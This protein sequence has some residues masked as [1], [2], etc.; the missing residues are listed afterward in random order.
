MCSIRSCRTPRGKKAYYGFFGSGLFRMTSYVRSVAICTQSVAVAMLLAPGVPAY[1]QDIAVKA[2]QCDACHG[3]TGIPSDPAT[4]VIWG[5]H[6]AYLARQIGEFKLGSRVN[7]QMLLL[8]RDM[9]DA[10]IVALAAHYAQK[11]PPK[12]NQPHASDAEEKRAQAAIV[13]GQCVACHGILGR[14]DGLNPRI[15][16]QSRSYILKTLEEFKSKTRGTNPWMS[17]ILGPL[18]TDDLAALAAFMAAR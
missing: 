9:P 14:G 6:Q 17:D 2:A 11:P 1:A 15:A 3:A 13:A 4:P 16:G 12:L 7:E 8:L 18:S 5:Q 10:E